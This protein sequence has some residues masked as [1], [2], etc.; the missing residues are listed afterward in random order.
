MV[1]GEVVPHESDGLHEREQL[2]GVGQQFDFERR[3]EI[4][5]RLDITAR[6][7][8]EKFLVEAHVVE[9]RVVL[10]SCVGRRAQEIAVVAEKEA[11]HH[12]VEVDD[13]QEF[14]R[15]GIEHHVID[16]RVAVADATRQFSLAEQP[17]ALTHPLGILL[18]QVENVLHTGHATDGVFRHDLAQLLHTEFHVVE[19]GNRVAER[20]RHIDE[21]FFKVAESH[22]CEVAVLWVHRL[23]GLR[24]RN[25]HH[26]APIAVFVVA[27]EGLSVVG[28]DESQHLAVDVV[29]T[30]LFEFAADVFCHHFDVV[31]QQIDIRE[32]GVV[33]ALQHVVWRVCGSGFH[34]IRVVDQA[35]AKRLHFG[36]LAAEFE[37]RQD[38]LEIYCHKFNLQFYDLTI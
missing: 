29:L 20:L 17:F 5:C 22:A 6:E 13:K 23:E 34:S 18:K 2:D 16:F 38:F 8:L 4:A 1:A 9:V 3:E 35:V 14:S 21:Q 19:V 24:P 28:F 36:H 7:C 37:L 31:L 32:N 12:R 11:R 10:G 27:E 30:A 25:E 15:F 33:D 26:H